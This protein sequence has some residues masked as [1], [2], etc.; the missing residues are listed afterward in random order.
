MFY[1]WTQSLSMISFNFKYLCIF[2]LPW[3]FFLTNK[4][5]SLERNGNLMVPNWEETTCCHHGDWVHDGFIINCMF[6]D[7]SWAARAVTLSGHAFRPVRTS[8]LR[9]CSLLLTITT[10]EVTWGSH[11]CLVMLV[12]SCSRGSVC[13]C[14]FHSVSLLLS[15]G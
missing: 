10:R 4:K 12:M 13:V 2:F 11:G 1:R 7:T 14:F 5:K 15:L 3:L 8:V 6:A 9:V